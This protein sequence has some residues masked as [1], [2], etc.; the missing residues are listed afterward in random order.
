MALATYSDLTSSITSWLYA[1]TDIAAN[2]ADFI[3]LAEANLN[4][5]IVDPDSPVAEVVKLRT[6]DM[7]T[8]VEI[9]PDSDGHAD[10]PTDF[11]E[12]RQVTSLNSPRRPLSLVAPS[13][14]E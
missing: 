8:L 14:A 1:R 11:L 3:A 9:T 4:N 7:E 5:G 6:R 2:A 13:F 10:L 12:Y